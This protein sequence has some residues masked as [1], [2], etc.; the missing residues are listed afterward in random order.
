[1]T[2]AKTLYKKEYFQRI[3]ELKEYAPTGST[4]DHGVNV[5]HAYHYNHF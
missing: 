4:I 3:H 5:L 1:M 2:M